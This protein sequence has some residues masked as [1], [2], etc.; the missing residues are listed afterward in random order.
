MHGLGRKGVIIPGRL[1]QPVISG[2]KVFVASIDSHTLHVLRADDGREVWQYTAGGRIDSSPTVYKG[3]VLFGAADGWVYCLGAAD[4]RPLWRFR[5]APEERLVGVY[6]QLESAWP[7]HGAVLV[8]NDT[9]Y[10]TAGRSTYMDGG[11]VLYRIDPVTGKELSKTVLCHLDPDTGKQLVPERKF[12]MEG[13]TSDILSGD[14]ESVYLKYFG[15]DRTGKRTRA[16]K[17]HLFSITGLLGE[18]WFVRSY[19][20]VGSGMPGAGWGGWANAAKSFPS[21]RILCFNKDSVFGYG[22]QSVAGGAVGHRADAYHLFSMDRKDRKTA[23]PQISRRG[24]GRK[25]TPAKGKIGWTDARSLI[26]R[27]MVLTADRLAVAGPVDLGKKEPKM[28]AFTNEAEALAG[29]RG[30]KGVY[31]RIVSTADGKKISEHK[32]SAMP[33][34]DGMSAAG[35]KLYLSLKNGSVVCFGK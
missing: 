28:L 25:K 30:E 3:T 19:W 9:L 31:L 8:Q 7:V 16:T 29:F 18:E 6:G 21:G 1:T 20:I 35:G 24:R 12:N 27:A 26:V 5:A 17:P 33:I 13:T 4:G 11:I 10:V 2:G 32:L 34:F 14:G 15:F 22:R 23:T